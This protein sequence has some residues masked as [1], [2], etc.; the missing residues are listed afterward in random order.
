MW[1]GSGLC[2]DGS[3]LLQCLVLGLQCSFHAHTAVS[4]ML[5]GSAFSRTCFFFVKKTREGSG[6]SVVCSEFGRWGQRGGSHD[7]MRNEQETKGS[8]V[9]LGLALSYSLWCIWSAE[10]W[11]LPLL[12]FRG[13][14]EHSGLRGSQ[15][16]RT[17]QSRKFLYLLQVS[18]HK[19]SRLEGLK[20]PSS[21]DPPVGA[22]TGATLTGRGALLGR[23]ACLSDGSES[24]GPAAERNPTWMDNPSKQS[25]VAML[26]AN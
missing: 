23:T 18:L 11:D 4:S 9:Y 16:T 12:G 6:C 19:Y 13:G 14:Q 3:H 26:W 24:W 5:S 10:S 7:F 8:Q 25:L 22:R 21:P 2:L 20:D 17:D 1:R 15:S